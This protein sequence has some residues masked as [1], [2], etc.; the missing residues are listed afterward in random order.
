[1]L[2]KSRPR[3]RP[4][5]HYV[6]SI[7]NLTLAM[8]ASPVCPTTSSRNIK[9]LLFGPHYFEEDDRERLRTPRTRYTVFPIE[10]TYFMMKRLDTLFR[11]EDLEEDF[12]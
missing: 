2:K 8:A 3:G 9:S 7:Q 1:M 4:H 11:W 12:F 6:S 5:S 10:G